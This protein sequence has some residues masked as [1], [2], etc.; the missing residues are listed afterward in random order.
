M[1]RTLSHP[2]SPRQCEV[3]VAS[4]S[5]EQR[6]VLLKKKY[7]NIKRNPWNPVILSKLLAR[8]TRL[9]VWTHFTLILILVVHA[10]GY[11]NNTPTQDL[12]IDTGQRSATSGKFVEKHN[13]LLITT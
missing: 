10:E 2:S 7:A 13:G 5:G 8:Y 9:K 3:V 4:A 6:T 12:Q 1:C 11:V